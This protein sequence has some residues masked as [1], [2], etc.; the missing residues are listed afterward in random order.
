GR[1][2]HDAVRSIMD[3]IDQTTKEYRAVMAIDFHKAF[4][5]ISHSYIIKMCGQYGFSP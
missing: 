5:S 3:S 1:Y 2:M 4:D